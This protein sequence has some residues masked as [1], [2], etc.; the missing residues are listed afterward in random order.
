MSQTM[1]ARDFPSPDRA[2][3]ASAAPDRVYADLRDRI[4]SL[5]LPP[6][7]TLG[8]NDIAQ[9]YGVSQTPV[10][11]A[12]Q[13]LEEDGLVQIFPQSKTVVSQ[14]DVRQLYETQVLRVAIET[15]I[16]R[17]LAATKGGETLKH[18]AAILRM[19]Q[20]LLGTD[21][22]AMFTDLDRAF[23]R[24]LFDGV[25]MVPLHLMLLRRLGHLYRCQRLELPHEGRMEAIVEA[26]QAII[27]GIASGGGERAAEEMRK[28]L[29]GTISRVPSLLASHPDYF[30][31]SDTG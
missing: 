2:A 31:G 24:T 12:L 30:T 21:E 1:Q 16:V 7:T 3:T 14:I 5:E 4:V 17:R 18:A 13:R 19:Q 29:S 27:D 11:E 10:R 25:G 8:R 26:H 6:G 20:A 28:H 15:E 23:H 9:H 22:T